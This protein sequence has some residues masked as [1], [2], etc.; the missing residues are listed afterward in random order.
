MTKLINNQPAFRIKRVFFPFER[1]RLF[2][3]KILEFNL[4][5]FK[6][7]IL[8]K[9]Y[10]S[11]VPKNDIIDSASMNFFGEGGKR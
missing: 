8:K 1:V 10:R 7:R 4:F 2:W 9:E 6:V 11:Q 5:H 3:K